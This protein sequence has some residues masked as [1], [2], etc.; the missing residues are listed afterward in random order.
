M[1]VCE[2]CETENKDNATKCS[3]CGGNQFRY[4]CSNC[5]NVF[6]EGQ[7]C[8][9]CGVKFGQKARLCPRCGREYYTAACPDCGYLSGAA[10]EKTVCTEKKRHTALWVLGWIFMFPIPLTILTVR[11]NRIPTWLKAVIIIAAWGVYALLGI[12]GSKDEENPGTSSTGTSVCFVS[13]CNE[14]IQGGAYYIL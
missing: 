7:F 6:D 10:G 1:K 3:A 4:K 12:K 5:G 14:N 13:T 2:F 9:S 11:S 8:P